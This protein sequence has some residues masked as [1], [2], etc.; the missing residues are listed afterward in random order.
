VE[1]EVEVREPAEV[2]LS[3]LMFP[4]WEVAVDGINVEATQSSGISRSVSIPAGQHVIRWRYRPQS[5]QWGAIVSLLSVAALAIC[6]IRRRDNN[7]RG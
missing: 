4:G 5:F 2:H 1:F 6:C 7:S 3:E